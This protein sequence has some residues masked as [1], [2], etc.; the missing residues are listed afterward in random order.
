[1]EIIIWFIILRLP[2]S[3]G[4]EITGNRRLISGLGSPGGGGVQMMVSL[5]GKGC[6]NLW[7]GN[8]SNWFFWKYYSKSNMIL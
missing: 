7:Y 5:K 6:G 1:M 8:I 3:W 2:S 4:S